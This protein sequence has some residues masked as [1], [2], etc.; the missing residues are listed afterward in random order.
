[1]NT[2]TSLVYVIQAADPP[3]ELQAQYGSQGD[4]FTQALAHQGWNVHVLRPH[5]GDPLPASD[6]PHPVIISGS[7]AM[8]T[9]R[10]PWSEAMA[11]WIRERYPTDAPLFGVC[12]GHQ[13]MAYALG[14]VVDYHPQGRELGC[15][16]VWQLETVL[17]PHEAELLDAVATSFPAFLTHEQ[18]V[19][20]IPDGA[21]VLLRSEH[22]PHQMLSYRAGFYSVQFHPEFTVNLLGATIKR[23]A[24]QLQAE[25]QDVDN[26]LAQLQDTPEAHGLL[27]QFV[28]TYS[29]ALPT[30]EERTN[31]PGGIP[32]SSLNAATNADILS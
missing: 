2:T 29:P 12:Y 22:D 1:M 17:K 16:N 20:R 9:D 5:A 11:A 25:G 24:Q 8:V 21:K 13:L 30:T 18:S 26:L 32:I 10:E 7:W 23:R 15:L 27:L 6:D 19:L 31:S 14:G 4:W 28:H 3:A